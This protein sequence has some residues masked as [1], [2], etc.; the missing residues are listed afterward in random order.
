MLIANLLKTYLFVLVLNGSNLQAA[1][2]D[3]ANLKIVSLRDANLVV[4]CT[5]GTYMIGA[6]LVGTNSIVRDLSSANLQ[7]A[8]LMDL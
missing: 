6:L 4:A 2:L 7:N 5:R 8:N 1:K 3:F